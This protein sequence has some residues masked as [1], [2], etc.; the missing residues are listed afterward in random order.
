MFLGEAML[1]HAAGDAGASELGPRACWLREGRV[2][3]GQ[4]ESWHAGV[5]GWRGGCMEGRGCPSI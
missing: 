1:L 5:R 3:G 2:E 4:A